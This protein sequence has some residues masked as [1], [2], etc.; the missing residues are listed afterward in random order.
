MLDSISIKIWLER[1]LSNWN[2]IKGFPHAFQVWSDQVEK[3]G[4]TQGNI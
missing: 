3:Y 2:K 4:V 1:S